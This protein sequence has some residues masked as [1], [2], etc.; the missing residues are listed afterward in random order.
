M[1]DLTLMMVLIGAGTVSRWFVRAVD[2]L[3]GRRR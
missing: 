2:K 3:E 1:E